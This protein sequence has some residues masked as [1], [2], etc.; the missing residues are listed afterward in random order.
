MAR[1]HVFSESFKPSLAAPACNRQRQ[2][3]TLGTPQC[4]AHAG[5]FSMEA[6]LT[7]PLEWK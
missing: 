3:K 4:L 7:G 5:L 6:N 2:D 1:K